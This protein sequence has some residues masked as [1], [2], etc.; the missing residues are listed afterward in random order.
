MQNGTGAELK[1]FMADAPMPE[2][3][4]VGLHAL[5]LQMGDVVDIILQ[6]TP[7]AAFNGDYR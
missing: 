6:N 1:V 5:Q 3:P 4:S 2:N 7:S